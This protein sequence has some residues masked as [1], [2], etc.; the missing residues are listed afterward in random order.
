MI[1][2]MTAEPS[3]AL[4]D[5]LMNQPD[6]PDGPVKSGQILESSG[7]TD[8]IAKDGFVFSAGNSKVPRE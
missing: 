2:G 3:L 1:F 6:I 8:I 5:V 7:P 4:R